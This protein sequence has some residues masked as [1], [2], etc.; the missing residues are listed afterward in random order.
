MRAWIAEDQV[1]ASVRLEPVLVLLC[2]ALASWVAY[3]IFLRKV[4]PERHK[5]FRN[6]FRNLLGHIVI[7]VTLFGIYEILVL[8]SEASVE[9][10]WLL[11]LILYVGFFTVIW[12]CIV[13]I[14]IL[15]IVAYE[16][17]F[18]TSMKAGVPLLLVNILTLVLS[19]V[20][21]GWIFTTF[22]GVHL[23]PLLATSAIFSIVLGLALQDTLGNLFAGVALQIDKP[24]ELGDWI[25]VKNGPDKIAGQVQEISWR[26][27][28]LL[29]ITE[30]F[31]TI[32]NRSLAQWQI[33][34]FAARERSFIRSHI[35]RIPHDGPLDAAK[36]ALL[37]AM[38]SVSGVLQYPVPVVI[39]TETTESWIALK[40]I[41][42][43][44]DYGAQYGVADRFYATALRNLQAAGV[45]MATSHLTIARRRDPRD[46]TGASG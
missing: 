13:L 33:S 29:A 20:A 25:E 46:P 16:Y 5:I 44:T 3:K 14:K 23:T 1:T 36:K 41:Y 31:I 24:F 43:I 18:L 27:T 39:V 40:A 45:S 35:F 42:N 2:F 6:H 38:H 7:G 34:N 15:R 17:L 30:E 12:G 9:S 8:A 22:F 28:V 4:S 21:G 11:K 26:A 37:E 19:L 32:P 10:V